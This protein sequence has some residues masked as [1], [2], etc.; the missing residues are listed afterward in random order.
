MG[1]VDV[2]LKRL[3]EVEISVDFTPPASLWGRFGNLPL[4]WISRDWVPPKSALEAFS[5]TSLNSHSR[6]LTIDQ[7]FP[8]TASERL[9]LENIRVPVEWI[10]SQ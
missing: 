5:T 3:D 1:G 4:H 2:A 6:K 8:L 10:H 7:D 9:R